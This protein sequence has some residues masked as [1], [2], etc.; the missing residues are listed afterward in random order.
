MVDD[1]GNQ[2]RVHQEPGR[3]QHAEALADAVLHAQGNQAV[4]AEINEHIRGPDVI[5]A[6]TAF[7]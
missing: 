4:S 2:G 1:T 3:Q 7:Q 5:H 6:K